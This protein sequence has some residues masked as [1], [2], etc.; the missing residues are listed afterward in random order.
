MEFLIASLKELATNEI[1]RLIRGKD[2]VRW[3][4]DELETLI[5]QLERIEDVTEVSKEF[6]GWRD[7]IRRAEDL[8]ETYTKREIQREA[9][10][11]KGPIYTIKIWSIYTIKIWSIS[12]QLYG[13]KHE[14]ERLRDSARYI[15]HD[16]V[17][18]PRNHSAVEQHQ[19]QHQTI[20]SHLRRCIHYLL[21]FPPDFKVP[22]RRLIALWVAEGLVRTNKYNNQSVEQIA[23]RY[24][25]ELVAQKV[26]SFEEGKAGSKKAKAYWIDVGRRADLL[27]DAENANFFQ[28]RNGKILRLAD[29]NDTTGDSFIQIPISLSDSLQDYRDV[30]SFLSFNTEEGSKPGEDIEYFLRKYISAKCFIWLRVLDLERVFRPQLPSTLGKLIGLKYLGL[31][32][33]YLEHLPDSVEKLF[34]LQ[35][36]DVKHTYISILP[37]SIW[38]MEYLRHLYLSEAYRTRFPLPPSRITL[39]ALQS[40]WGAFVDED[41]CVI[42]G[43]DTLLNVRKL[44]LSCRSRSSKPDDMT[45][46]LQA[47]DKW[48]SKLE[49][50]ESLRLKSR[51]ESG[52]AVDLHLT[53]LA[54]NRKL[55]KVYLLGRLDP[56]ILYKLPVS[57]TDITLS[58]SALDLDPMPY[59]GRLP[60]LVILR[61]LAKSVVW[62]NMYCPRRGFR[63]LEILW[64]WNLESLEEFEAEEGSLSCLKEL[65]I[66]S[67][68]KLG[69]LPD[70]L[71]ELENLEIKL[72]NM[73]LEFVQKTLGKYVQT[74]AV[75]EEGFVQCILKPTRLTRETKG[76]SVLVE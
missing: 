40:L 75:K 65:E 22:A 13:I 17:N 25:N 69:K 50:L 43:L 18:I 23:Q 68:N 61:L 14:M 32:W 60:N 29:C 6:N 31:R 38:R 8:S 10:A 5:P 74:R 33:T 15:R 53:S 9:V 19:H 47:I 46:Q 20:P 56:L 26:I 28:H 1:N 45:K 36:L 37:T 63:R 72:T 67:C 27:Q 52:E 41:T 34:N 73:P 48:I 62:K 11:F 57:L 2:V 35:V 30:V 54:G 16:E 70:R 59:L 76:K 21:L 55:S 44:G 64:I 51:D 3:L 49:F 12:K 66:R 39:T 71:C 7:A 58:G 4:E 24:L 42:N